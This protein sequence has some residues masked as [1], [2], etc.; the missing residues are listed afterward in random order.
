MSEAT[1]R[2]AAPDDVPAL[3][4]LIESAYRGDSAKA[5]W[6]HEADLLGGQ[7]TDEAE[8]RD[9]LADASRVLLLAEI[10]G[11]LTGC[12]QVAKQGEGLAY[13]GLLTVDPR[14]QAGGLGRWLIAAAEAEAIDRFGATRMEMTVIRQRVE[15]IAWYERRG[16]RLTGETRP[17]PLD[18]ERFGL[19]QTRE[20]EFVVLEK[21]L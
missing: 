7:R 18:D 4:R 13:L 5:G 6:T 1:F 2:P 20:L 3:H 19:P 21:A 16:Y 10:D 11:V 14:R 9:I 8:L 17:F 12:V 15:L